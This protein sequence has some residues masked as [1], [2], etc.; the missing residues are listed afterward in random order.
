MT[1]ALAWTNLALDL[2]QGAALGIVPSLL[3]KHMS[4]RLLAVDVALGISGCL[5]MAWFLAPLRWQGDPSRFADP[6]ILTGLGSAFAI[7]LGRLLA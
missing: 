7:A 5:A 4:K 2:A 3:S 6:G 1:M